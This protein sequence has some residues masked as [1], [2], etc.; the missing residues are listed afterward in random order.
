MRKSP[1]SKVLFH[2]FLVLALTIFIAGCQT[3]YTNMSREG[4]NAKMAPARFSV[5]PQTVFGYNPIIHYIDGRKIKRSLWDGS[6]EIDLSSGP[7]IVGMTFTKGTLF[8]IEYSRT[9]EV[10]KFVAKPGHH[11]QPKIIYTNEGGD[12]R[13]D[14]EVIDE[15]TGKVFKHE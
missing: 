1:L 3:P 5:P 8:G 9:I 11:Y 7:H 4:I 10:V 6:A 12:N 2:S 13:W 14:A 15:D